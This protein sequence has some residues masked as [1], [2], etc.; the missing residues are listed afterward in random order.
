[1]SRRIDI[2]LTSAR[3]DG[4]WTWRAAGARQP[5]GVLDSKLLYDGAKAGDVVRAEAEFEIEGITITQVIPPKGKRAEPERLELIGRSSEVPLVT[6]SLVPKSDRRPQ[7][8]DRDGERRGPRREGDRGGPRSGGPGR[9]PRPEGDRS[10][11]PPRG[12]GRGDRAGGGTREGREAR[13]PREAREGRPPRQPRP[14]ATGRPPPPKPKRLN[15]GHTHR[16]AVLETL[17]P[18]QRPIAEQVLRGG[19]PAVRAAIE[20]ENEKAK[21]EGRPAVNADAIV[22]MAEGLLPRLETAEWHDR[23]D[24]AAQSVDEISLRD[25]RAVVTGADAAA[26]DDETRTLASTLRDALERRVEAQRQEWVNEME[27]CLTEGR[28]VRA[29]RVA[30]RP[31]DPGSR[32]PAE[33]AGRM[34]DAAGTAMAPDAPADRWTV[35]ID[36]V[37]NSPV[38]RQVTPAGLPAEPGEE[39]LQRAREA[40]GRIPALAKMLGIDMPPP[41]RPTRAA[42]GRAPGKPARR[43]A[44]GGRP[45]PPPPRGEPAR[46]PPRRGPSG[47]PPPPQ[48]NRGRPP[49][50]QRHRRPPW[51]SR[52]PNRW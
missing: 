51:S 37:A 39:L 22:A 14:A 10:S 21:A 35:L 2:E 49:P 28:L 48:P 33:L 43:P 1:M 8:G 34:A 9:P 27:S 12:E 46:A 50:H 38:R 3:D 23:A 11:R 30:A 31:P 26:R 36:A 41:P 19:I 52:H 25:L 40:S 32:F 29:L 7:R 20:Q 5:K 24:A 17:A 6:S 42:P 15:P 45:V 4:T 13:P 47:S 16:T 44:G 18:E